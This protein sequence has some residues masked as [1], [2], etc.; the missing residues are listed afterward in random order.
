M[1]RPSLLPLRRL[2]G[3]GKARLSLLSRRSAGVLGEKPAG[4][5]LNGWL[6]DPRV[7]GVAFIVLG[8]VL[9]LGAYQSTLESS[10]K[11]WLLRH[12]PSAEVWERALRERDYRPLTD[13]EALG[14]FLKQFPA[15]SVGEGEFFTSE[16]RFWI[17]KF[18]V[19]ER[20][21]SDWKVYVLG[22][23]TPTIPHPQEWEA[24]GTS[25]EALDRFWALK[26]PI[27]IGNSKPSPRR[28]EARDPREIVF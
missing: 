7:R 23:G 13:P 5:A 19:E 21:E 1:E 18:P 14:K 4:A 2:L 15:H 22:P 11:Q 9:S 10:R 12:A 16:N 8:G 6:K 17:V 25:Y 20:G 26:L 28:K 3:A 27:L 24:L